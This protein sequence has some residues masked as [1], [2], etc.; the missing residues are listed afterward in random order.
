MLKPV[1][2]SAQPGIPSLV[3]FLP[4]GVGK[5][6]W[7]ERMGIKQWSAPARG[8]SSSTQFYFDCYILPLRELCSKELEALCRPE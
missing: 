7:V 8:Q 6:Y 5:L 4:L 2:A 1:N 3:L